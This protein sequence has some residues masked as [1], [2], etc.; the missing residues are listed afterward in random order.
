MAK[1]YRYS[2]GDHVVWTKTVQN[3]TTGQ[4]E[5]HEYPAQIKKRANGRQAV[6][7]QSHDGF[8]FDEVRI[9]RAMTPEEIEAMEGV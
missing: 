3:W 6:I 8:W 1:K 5:T 2:I 9:I 7:Y 4:K